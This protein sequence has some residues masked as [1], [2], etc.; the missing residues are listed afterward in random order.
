MTDINYQEKRKLPEVRSC[1]TCSS[2]IRASNGG[3]LV[4]DLL[5]FMETGEL[6]PRIREVCGICAMTIKPED[7]K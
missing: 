3:V 5:E 2:E 6:P 7:I 4:R 1:Y